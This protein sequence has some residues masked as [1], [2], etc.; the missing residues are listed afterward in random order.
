LKR[1]LQHIAEVSSNHQL[2]QERIYGSPGDKVRIV[3]GPLCGTRGVVL[4]LKPK[5]RN[6]VLEISFLG[7]R[8]EVE[9]EEHQ[10]EKE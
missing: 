8:V 6:L 7:V 2:I 3:S 4:A 10:V 1:E 5:K 9:V